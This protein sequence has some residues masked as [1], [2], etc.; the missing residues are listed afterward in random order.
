VRTKPLFGADPSAV[1]T[2]EPR[3]PDF[4]LPRCGYA[5]LTSTK[6]RTRQENCAGVEFDYTCRKMTCG[7]GLQVT[8][9]VGLQVG[10]EF[11]HRLA[12]WV[13][14]PGHPGCAADPPV[15]ERYEPH[16]RQL[17][18]GVVFGVPP[19]APCHQYAVAEANRPRLL[20]GEALEEAHG[21]D[22]DCGPRAWPSSVQRF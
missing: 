20:N 17:I 2:F 18:Q 7:V 3:F 1:D 12:I 5:P 22:P 21:D 16:C 15:L 19:H 13:H 4:L 9:G 6:T 11:D 8:C 10:V 14:Q